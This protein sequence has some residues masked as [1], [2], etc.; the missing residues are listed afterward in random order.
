MAQGSEA[1]GHRGTFVG[2]FERGLV[3]TMALVPQVV[4]AVRVPVVAAG[5]IMDGRG[6]VAA[7]ALGAAGVQLGIGVPRLRRVWRDPGVQGGG[8]RGD[9]RRHGGHPRLLRATGARSGEPLPE[10]RR[11]APGEHP[12]VPAP[13]RAHPA[14]ADR[15]GACRTGRAAVPVGR[16]RQPG[17]PG[18]DPRRRSSAGWWRTPRGS[19]RRSRAEDDGQRQLLRSGAV[20][21]FLSA[22]RQT[23]RRDGAAAG[24][25]ATC[26]RRA[27]RP[28]TPSRHRRRTA[29]GTPA[30]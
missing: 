8:A 13:E 10:R 16:D 7:E 18:A 5:G 25:A 1:G 20:W 23:L 3:G 27:A 26:G 24:A 12:A 28:A 2:S 11:G 15:G 30:R 19:G 4:D 22:A 29:R 14:D 9:G 6:W 17:W 21:L